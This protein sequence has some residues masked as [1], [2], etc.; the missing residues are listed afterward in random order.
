MQNISLGENIMK[1]YRHS[2]APLEVH[3]LPFY[4]CNGLL[5]RVPHDVLK[6]LKSENPDSGVIRLSKRTPGARICFRTNS[7]KFTV[8]MELASIT[9]DVGMSIFAC[10]AVNVMIGPHTSAR[11]AGLVNPP[12]YTTLSASKTFYKSDETE[13]VV[14]FLPR[15]E[16]VNYI[17]VEVDDDAIVES[18]TPYKY[19]PILFYGSSITE[20]GCCC[21]LTNSY[22]ALISS[23]LDVDYYNY[24]FSGSARGEL[25]LANCIADI[26][27][28]V[29]VYDYDHNAPDVEH[30]EKTHEPFFKCIREK[31]KKL[32]IV[33]ITRPEYGHSDDSD[34]RAQVIYRT[35]KNAVD[36]GDK[37]VYFIDGREFFGENGALCSCDCCHPNDLG[38]YMMA[39]KISPVIKK[40]L[41]AK[42]KK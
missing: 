8:R 11:F 1:T 6:E 38:F 5:E 4:G 15:N 18:P 33:M 14:L 25:A 22:T 27:M 32:P 3:G 7:K 29:F 23:K 9:P 21:R 40:I 19:P 42:Y 34:R 30:L 28:S 17:E 10:Q 24:G 13:D 36:S 20:G 26:P 35:Y 2:D 41:E 37:N 31:N 12:D 16:H 39:E